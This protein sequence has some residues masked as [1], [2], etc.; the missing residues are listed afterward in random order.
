[1]KSSKKSLLM[2]DDDGD[3]C[4]STRLA[5]ERFGYQV[6]TAEDGE[7]GLEEIRR[8]RPDVILLDL[9]MP[10]MDGFE[11]LR[12]LRASGNRNIPVLVL[13]AKNQPDDHIL[14]MKC[15]ADDFIAKPFDQNVLRAH[16]ERLAEKAATVSRNVF[17]C[18]SRADRDIVGPLV[19][20]I[21]ASGATTFR[22][23]E[24][25]RKGALWRAEIRTALE[26]CDTVLV[27][28]SRSAARSLDVR[29]EYARAIRL[30]KEIVPVF[31]DGTEVPVELKARQG[32]VLPNGTEIGAAAKREAKTASDGGENG[33]MP[34]ETVE[35]DVAASV[36]AAGLLVH[37]E[38]GKIILDKP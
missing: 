22:D 15:G 12:Q 9:M 24:D 29:K 28:W 27:F 34:A 35:E 37:A 16:V 11:T 8:E 5:F 3:L 18:Y 10:K 4:D 33:A 1:M 13:T 19:E 6:A 17:I 21:R 14:A 20:V 2:I 31:L 23:V 7:K 26:D 38:V 36:L 32:V 30:G 25:I